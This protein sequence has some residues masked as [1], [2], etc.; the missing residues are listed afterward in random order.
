LCYATDELLQDSVLVGQ[1]IGEAARN[2][3]TFLSEDAIF[4]GT[5]VGMPLGIL[6]SPALISQAKE[7]G[8]AAATVVAENIINM[9]SR[10][11]AHGNYAWFI[12]Q[13]VEP[14]L[15][16]MALPVG[17]GGALVYMPP[18]GLSASPYGSL[19]GRP[20]IVTEYNSAVGTV[21]DI[22]LADMSQYFLATKGGIQEA[23]SIHVH[24]IYDESVFR[25]V[26]RVDGQ[27]SWSSALTP[28][29]AT[30]GRTVSPFVALAVRA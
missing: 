21:G 13:E 6:N 25:F 3:L 26:M 2:E 7:A 12:N 23:M 18:G 4:N 15:H 19:Y 17:V 28:F 27:P 30:A 8:Q 11:W 22:V 24:F 29:K 1:V 20:V 5:G 9:W 16:Q 14:Q 10:R